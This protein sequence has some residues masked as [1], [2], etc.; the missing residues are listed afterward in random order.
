MID[1]SHTGAKRR[2]IEAAPPASSSLPPQHVEPAPHRLTGDLLIRV[3]RCLNEPDR[4]NVACV[5]HGFFAA[6]KEARVAEVR[7]ASS[8]PGRLSDEWLPTA[9]ELAQRGCSRPHYRNILTALR[10]AAPTGAIA[11]PLGDFYEKAAA[12]Q[13]VA[14]FPAANHDTMLSMAQG[15]GAAAP[16]HGFAHRVTA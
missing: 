4:N 7:E 2:K 11:S 13:T 16:E 9:V 10:A 8:R 1:A 14:P 12:L 5:S 15:A 6:V 3:V